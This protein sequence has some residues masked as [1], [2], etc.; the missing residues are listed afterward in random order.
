MENNILNVNIDSLKK[1]SN[2]LSVINRNI[3]NYLSV[4]ENEY[5]NE[6]D[7]ILNTKASKEYK[8]KVIEY[9]DKTSNDL[10]NNNTYLINKLDDIVRIYSEL[11]T[12]INV[13]V[14]GGK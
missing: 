9:I 11:D 8:E 2:D 10:N 1:V 14:R 6:L 7:E 4:I 3:L 12:D 13:S 5:K